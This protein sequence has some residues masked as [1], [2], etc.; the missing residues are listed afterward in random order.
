MAETPDDVFQLKLGVRQGGP[1]SPLLYNLYMD[2]VMRVFT[3]LCDER[4]I[5]FLTLK[6]R[7]PP[8]AT[9]REE[10]LQK[11]NTGEHVV[12]WVGYADDL[13]LIFS[14]KINL[15]K[16]LDALEETFRK[17]HLTINIKKTKTIILNYKN[18][19]ESYPKTICSLKNKAVENV[20]TFRYLGDEIKYNEPSTGDSEV[21]L[22][23]ELAEAKFYEMSKK[24]L[25][26]DIRLSTRIMILNSVVRSRLTYSCQIWNL[27]TRQ[28]DQI[29]STYM[30]MIR[31][32]VK[33]GYRRKTET[34]WSFEK[35]NS[36]LHRICGTEDVSKYTARQQRNYLAHLARQPSTRLTKRLLFNCNE[37]RKRGPQPT[38]EK[39]VLQTEQCT[40]NEFY[41]KALN[42]DV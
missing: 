26:H 12:D 18:T 5:K 1:E 24:F 37:G 13:G 6:Y 4:E 17:Y 35:S 33:G 38:L 7:V 8:T 14:D 3:S 29:N 10:R 15:Q 23:I 9:T 2:F 36:E 30:A 11:T 42:R 27:T 28:T 16:G 20:E 40:A 31:K 41:R 21:Q 34:G 22:R 32:M 25:N 19:F 39:S